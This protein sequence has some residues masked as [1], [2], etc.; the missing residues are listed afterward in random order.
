[1]VLGFVRVTESIVSV[2]GGDNGEVKSKCG[3]RNSFN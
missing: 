3:K 2:C 1:L